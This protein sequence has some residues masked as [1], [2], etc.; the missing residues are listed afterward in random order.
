MGSSFGGSSTT[1]HSTSCGSPTGTPRRSGSSGGPDPVD[2]SL[3]RRGAATGGAMGAW[4]AWNGASRRRKA[5]LGSGAAVLLAGAAILAADRAVA[6]AG[7]GRIHDA[8][9]DVPA[10]DVALV[11]GTGPTTRGRPNAFYEARM[12]AAA[13]LFRAGV[14]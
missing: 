2:V 13:A 1:R 3:L 8:V 4:S 12:D 9:A 6:A 5:L 14:V 11:L 7:R 10:A